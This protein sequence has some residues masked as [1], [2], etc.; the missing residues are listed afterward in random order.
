MEDEVASSLLSLVVGWFEG[1]GGWM[2][3]WVGGVEI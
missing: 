1:L 2:V 3:G